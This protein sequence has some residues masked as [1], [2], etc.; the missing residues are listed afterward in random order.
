[1]K[2][3]SGADLLRTLVELLAEQN[4]V[5]ITYEIEVKEVSV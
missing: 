3:P 2:H 1:M 4:G 5:K